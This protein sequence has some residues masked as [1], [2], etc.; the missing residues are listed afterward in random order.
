[1][2]KPLDLAVVLA[3]LVLM[4]VLGLW[5]AAK[6][7][8]AGDYFAGGRT[9]NKFFMMMHALG[10]GTHADDPVGVVGAAFQRGIS[11][12][13]YTYVYLFATPFYWLIAPLFR[14]SRYLTMADFFEDRYSRGLGLMYTIMGV[15][16]FAI[17]TGTLL[18]G[19]ELITSAM[20]QGAVPGWASILVM[21][22]V[23]VAYGT[24]GGLM[25]TVVVEGIQGL[26]IIVMSLLLVPFGLAAVGGFHGMRAALA[27]SHFSLAA[28]QEVT[29]VWVLSASVAMLIGIVAQPHIMEVCASG[30]TEFEGRVGFTYGNYVKRSCALGWAVVGVIVAAMVAQGKIPS[31]GGHRELAFGTAIRTLL[32]SGFVGLMFA[33]ILAAQMSTLSAFMVA[34]SALLSRNLYQRYWLP[35]EP[36]EDTEGKVLRFGRFAGLIVVGLGVGFAFLVGGVTD[37]L[38]WF[39]ALNALLGVLVWAAVLWKPANAVGAWTAFGWMALIWLVVGPVGAKLGGPNHPWLGCYAD[40]SNLHC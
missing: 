34:G 31:L 38:A 12:I 2:F 22:L 17:N 14:R 37:A 8:S 39:W 20:T 7:R 21:T 6:I 16:I 18:K 5:Q 25:A 4:A 11:G 36:S 13:W 27:P 10:T 32:P 29:W 19:T 35:A 23:F 9:F 40:K 24:A 33:A 30:K 3:Y 1:M 15:L 26:L 28:P